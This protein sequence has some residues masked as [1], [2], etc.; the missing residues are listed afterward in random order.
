VEGLPK[1]KA[2]YDKNRTNGFEIVGIS[3]DQD[4]DI[5]TGFVAENKMPWPQYFDGQGEQN[6]FAVKFGVDRFPEMWLVDKKGNL[7]D[8]NA[9]FGLDGKVTKL[10]AE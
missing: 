10:L 4:K 3:M 8:I 1:V 6:K 5:L 9:R 7:R 2:A